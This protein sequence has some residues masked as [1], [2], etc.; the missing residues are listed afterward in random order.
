MSLADE[1]LADLDEIDNEDLE[2]KLNGIKE[3]VDEIEED[4]TNE[5]SFEP[6]DIDIPVRIIHNL[7]SKSVIDA[8]LKIGLN[9][10]ETNLESFSSIF[11]L[12]SFNQCI[13]DF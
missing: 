7:N 8:P 5:S 12:K 11:C 1:L 9:H 3:E 2:E 13:S 10:S 6:M 4:E